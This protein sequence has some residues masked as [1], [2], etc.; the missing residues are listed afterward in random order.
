M[1]IKKLYNSCLFYW[2]IISFLFITL[3]GC[4]GLTGKNAV[5]E[6]QSAVALVKWTR[7]SGDNMVNIPV[8]YGTRGVASST[9]TPGS[10]FGSISWSDSKGNLWLFGG[11][12]GKN[13]QKLHNDLWKF[14]GT[15]WTWISGDSNANQPA[16]YGT[17]GVA[18]GTNIPGARY[19][20]VSWTDSKDNLWLFGGYGYGPKKQK[21]YLNDLWKFDGKNWTWVSGDN[22]T[23]HSGIYGTKG[24]ANDTNKPGTRI[25]SMSWVDSKGNLWLFGGAGQAGKGFWGRLNDMWKF[26]P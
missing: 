1:K 5:T 10:R 21:G 3:T 11:D 24:V 17:R 15:N 25:D 19:G 14:D 16:N 13:A 26:E 2:V 7:V 23:D 6:N 20:S 12:S 8:N 18:A 4:G 9:N 22:T